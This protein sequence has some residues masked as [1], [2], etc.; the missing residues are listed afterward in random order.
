MKSLIRRL[1]RV[2][3]AVAGNVLLGVIGVVAGLI[4]DNV[5]LLVGGIAWILLATAV[6][7]ATYLVDPVIE[8]EVLY[9]EQQP[10]LTGVRAH[11]AHTKESAQVS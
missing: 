7:V 1:A 4:Q 3:H 8:G 2:Q 6:L 10:Q 5:V 9:F 11:A